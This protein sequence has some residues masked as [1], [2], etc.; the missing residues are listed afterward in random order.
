VVSLSFLGCQPRTPQTTAYGV[1][2][3]TGTWILNSARS[4]RVCD[5]PAEVAFIVDMDITGFSVCWYGVQSSRVD[6]EFISQYKGLDIVPLHPDLQQVGSPDLASRI[7]WIQT[8]LCAPALSFLF[9][10]H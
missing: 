6:L 8:N 5:S 2:T 3:G 4:W 9:R 1:V 10:F 7:T